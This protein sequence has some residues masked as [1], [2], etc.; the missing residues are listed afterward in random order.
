MSS[1]LE[2]RQYRILI[3]E[4]DPI[5]IAIISGFLGSLYTLYIAK[6]QEKAFS[7]LAETEIDLVLLD[8]NLPDGNGFQICRKLVSQK[9]IYRDIHIVFMT[10]MDKAEDEAKGITLG[11]HDYITKPINETVLKARLKLQFQLIRQKELLSNLARIDGTT[12][13]NNRRAFDDHIRSEWLRAT[14]EQHP[15]S[16]CLLDLDYFKQFNDTYGHPAGDECLR[17]LAKC[18]ESVVHRSSDFVAR[19]G[20]EEFA[21][22]FYK[23]E[24]QLA[25][26]MVRQALDKFMA[27][28]IPHARSEVSDYV[29]F[30]AGISGAVPVRNNDVNDIIR[31]ADKQLYDAKRGGRA[32]VCAGEMLKYKPY[33]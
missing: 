26:Q 5:N 27:K 14:R 28:K 33:C 4:D 9:H 15:I 11:A 32:R 30:S 31:A 8:I 23:T 1:V 6:T 18:L 24:T 3:V 19:Y 2:E 7:I 13:I 29:S 25:K 22:I 17:E 10:G 21:I 16:L 12:E 20:G